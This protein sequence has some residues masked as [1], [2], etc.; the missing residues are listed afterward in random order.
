MD[1]KCINCDWARYT[2]H[3]GKVG[4]AYWS[5]AYHEEIGNNS[6]SDED[7]NFEMYL[8]GL[9]DAWTGWVYLKRRPDKKESEFLGEGMMT[10]FCII[11]NE[12][13]QCNKFKNK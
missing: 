3:N 12:D 8:N 10:N 6:K 7:K 11:V 4:C 2:A 5:V 9:R 1:Q 13:G